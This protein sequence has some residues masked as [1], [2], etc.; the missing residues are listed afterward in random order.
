MEETT[1]RSSSDTNDDAV[2]WLAFGLGGLFVLI[3]LIAC[4]DQHNYA[5]DL[6]HQ[7]GL[8]DHVENV[9]E[10]LGLLKV[11]PWRHVTD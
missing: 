3:M 4:S 6:R 11:D 1:H 10:K 5:I 9:L 7:T 2:R 8:R